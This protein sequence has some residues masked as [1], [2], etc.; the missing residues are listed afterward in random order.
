MGQ[1]RYAD[2]FRVLDALTGAVLGK[3]TLEHP[4]VDEQPFAGRIDGIAVPGNI[5]CI[6]VGARDSVLGYCG[7]SYEMCLTTSL[8]SLAFSGTSQIETRTIGDAVYGNDSTGAAS[9]VLE[10]VYG[11]DSTGAGGFVLVF[12]SLLLPCVL[13]LVLVVL[14]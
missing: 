13:Q 6:A 5:R 3:R 14:V 2:E 8:E 9:F 4:H 12:G 10:T 7:R 1:V 11:N